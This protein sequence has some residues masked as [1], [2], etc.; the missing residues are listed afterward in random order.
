LKTKRRTK[1]RRRRRGRALA[2]GALAAL[3]AFLIVSALESGRPVVQAT[4]KMPP[5]ASVRAKRL[6]W[7]IVRARVAGRLP[8]PVMG[9]ALAVSPGGVY[10]V[11]GYSGQAFLSSVEQ[12]QPRVRPWSRLPQSGHDAAAGFIGHTLYVFGGGQSASYSSIVAARAGEGALA[13]RLAKPLSDAACLPFA[14]NGHSDL[15]LIGGYDGFQFRAHAEFVTP[16][17][18]GFLWRRAFA[19]PQGGLR[20]VAVARSGPT[21]YLAGGLGR[22]GPSAAVYRWSQGARRPRVFARLPGAVYQAAAWAVPGYL[23][24]AGG[25]DAAGSPQSGIYAVSLATGRVRRVG[26]L[27]RTLGDMGY[28]PVGRSLL[29]AGGESGPSGQEVMNTIMEL[30]YRE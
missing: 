30:T 14:E 25:V 29:L 13:G 10:E 28:A 24:V 8:V 9:A 3:L 23:I 5:G 12:I 15:L 22:N 6:P 27:P 26:A 18:N 21:V 11:G 1:S 7:P 4:R 16:V 2:G 19:M 20:Y 17:R